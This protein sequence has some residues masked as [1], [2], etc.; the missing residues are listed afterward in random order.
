[1]KFPCE[2]Y[3]AFCE[4]RAGHGV[5]VSARGQASFLDTKCVL[6]GFDELSLAPVPAGSMG[7][8][9]RPFNNREPDSELAQQR[10]GNRESNCYVCLWSQ[11]SSC[12]LNS[13]MILTP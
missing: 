2:Q 13:V 8:M 1:M 3:Y 10:K 5:G 6:A 12:G 9:S 4:V 7:T 11:F